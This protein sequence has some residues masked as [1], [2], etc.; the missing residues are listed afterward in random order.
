M[1][2][3]AEKRG[4]DRVVGVGEGGSGRECAGI[5]TCNSVKV[6]C[7]WCAGGTETDRKE[8]LAVGSQRDGSFVA[9]YGGV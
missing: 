1:V 5:G 4:V 8:T 7:S 6:V 2:V 3:G 9:E